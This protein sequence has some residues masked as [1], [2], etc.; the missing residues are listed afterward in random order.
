MLCF[1]S[2][3]SFPLDLELNFEVTGFAPSPLPEAE[4]FEE[5]HIRRARACQ[6][7]RAREDILMLFNN[8]GPAGVNGVSFFYIKYKG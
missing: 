4:C 1:L 7:T 5:L 6:A 2:S 3:C 8:Y